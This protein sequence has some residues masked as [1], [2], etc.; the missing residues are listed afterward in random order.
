MKNT[1]HLIIC[2]FIS[3][4]IFAQP[5]DSE[6]K[7]RATSA[8]AI[9][10]RF[11]T[12]KGTIHTTLTEKWYMR[13][14]ESKWKS[15]YAGIF[16]WER[17]EYR[18]DF[19][20]GKWVFERSYLNSSWFEGV[21]NPS[22]EEIVANLQQSKVGYQNAV[23][24]KPVFKLAQDPKWNWHTIN[25][26]EFMV[27]VVFYEKISYTQVAKKKVVMPIRLYKDTGNGQHDPNKKVY[28]KESNWLETYSPTISS[29]YGSEETLELKEYSSE[30]AATIKTFLEQEL[31]AAEPVVEERIEEEIVEETFPSYLVE[32]LV[33]VNWNG[34]G[35]DFYDGKVVKIDPFNEN[36]YFIEFETIQSAWIE[37][38]FMS[39]RENTSKNASKEDSN[40]AKTKV[41]G[42]AS[43]IKFN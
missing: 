25:S 19:I 4:V 16:R 8:G 39:K 1:I 12:D 3:Q 29:K 40:D 9:E 28:I 35:K 32:E 17:T 31:D 14:M 5:L 36:R 23:L 22:E 42:A 11:T 26:V 20:G 30:E 10:T 2:F 13:T 37:A 7:Q 27:E 6:I 38:K 21:P 24:E 34:Q 18:Y 43:K 15:D 41:K 33:T